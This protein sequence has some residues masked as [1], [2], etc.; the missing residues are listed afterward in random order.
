M[1][2][3]EGFGRTLYAHT[4]GD[5]GPESWQLLSDHLRNVSTLAS[6][7][8][9]ELG[10]ANWG[11]ALG[12]LHDAGKVS[13]SFQDRLFGR[14]KAP[15]DH[16]A[17]G[18]HV[19]SES[20]HV[21][22]QAG[23]WLMAYA[24]VGH[25]GG[26]PNGKRDGEDG[27]SSLARRLENPIGPDD[28]A[29]YLDLLEQADLSLPPDES[30]EELP[31]VR[32]RRNP[33]PHAERMVY[34]TVLATRML[35]SCLVDADYLDT[36][37]FMTPEIAIERRVAASARSSMSE[38]LDRLNSHMAKLSVETVHSTVNEARARVLHA[39]EEASQSKPGLFTLTVPTGG[40]KTLSSLAFA[41]RHALAND[42]GRIIYAIPFT[43]IIEQTAEVFRDVL[44]EENVLEHHSNYDF[45]GVGDE[46]HI[47]ERL[48]TQNWDA[49]V[50][51]TTNVQ[52][53]ESLYA[54]RPARCR[55]L[56]NIANSVVVLDEAQ[57]LPDGLLRP[58]LAALE[59][60][61]LDF[62]SSVV[63]CTATQPALDSWWPFGSEPREIVPF[64]EDLVRALGNRT[65]FEFDGRVG[66]EELA[67]T[68]A[69]SRQALCIVGTKRKA[70]VLYEE[71]A[72]RVR[73]THTSSGGMD[74]PTELGVF[75]LST[76]MAP[77]HR[78]A[79]IAR[80]RVLLDRGKDCIV[81]STQLIEAGVDVDF[82]VVYREI[83]GVDS[84]VQAAGRCNRNGH[85]EIGT[86]HVFKFGDE[87]CFRQSPLG[88]SSGSSS[89]SD[90]KPA[91][92]AT[93]LDAM[94]A[95]AER[96]IERHGG[97]IDAATIIDFFEE[98]YDTAGRV[99][100][101]RGG[102]FER[103]SSMDL[104][105][106][107]FSA[108]DF[109]DCAHDYRIIDNDDAPVFVPWGPEGS[110]LMADLRALRK[111]GLP[112]AAM[113]SRLQ[114]SSIGIPRWRLEELRRAGFVDA[115]S[116][117]PIAVLN[118]EQNC[119]SY[120]SDEVGILWPGEEEAHTLVL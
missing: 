67:D 94:K 17:L 19:A 5:K 103:L 85:S 38:L 34:S 81:I 35:Y 2:E 37:S 111:R 12:L 31:L 71:V 44:G 13:Q 40:G 77:L 113:A 66:L 101:D 15:F 98:R 51:V 119:E 83:A 84:L 50:I 39:C 63:L 97:V 116:F 7:F 48:A 73:A 52:L 1:E 27:R 29:T 65:S 21:L 53:L 16:A 105:G 28:L 64:Q 90:A 45:D 3:G 74:E 89:V 32:I 42:M 96:V 58:S 26:M 107:S 92:G 80:I 87:D 43:S 33:N 11:R 8:A 6:A 91:L 61:A 75:H 120:Y 93:W 57:T 99:G 117:E 104:P 82:P 62:H 106:S 20:F 24:V 49:P 88:L 54:N 70:R 25:H 59:D 30:F 115:T 46:R 18:G 14:T 76:N 10:Y 41:L 110:G 72:A 47:R 114:R 60:L 108:I 23:G 68:L 109:D 55:K 118:L 4:F 9:G 112:A 95:M 102:V 100:L 69:G 22:G 56:H 79:W 78:A 86:V 36:E